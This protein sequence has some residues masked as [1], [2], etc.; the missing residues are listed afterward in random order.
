MRS[1]YRGG[2]SY[3]AT[4]YWIAFFRQYDQRDSRQ[5]NDPFYVCFDRGLAS[6]AW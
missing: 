3:R 6:L 4:R 1:H 5:V 2:N